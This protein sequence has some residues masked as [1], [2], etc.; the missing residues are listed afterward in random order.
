MKVNFFFFS[1]RGLWVSCCIDFAV[2]LDYF[3][4]G[5]SWRKWPNKTTFL[6]FFYVF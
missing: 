6:G 2:G 4:S 1:P 5:F 3:S